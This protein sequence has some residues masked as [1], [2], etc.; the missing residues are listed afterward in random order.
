MVEGFADFY[1]AAVFNQFGPGAWLGK[2]DIENDTRRYFAKCPGSLNS[3]VMQGYCGVQG[4]AT[5]CADAGG[6]NE[7]DWA[8]T[9][10]DFAKV[11]GVDE[12]PAVLLLLSDAIKLAWDPGSTTIDAYN[13]MR[14]AANLRFPAN[15]DDFHASAQAN[16]TNR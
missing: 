15:G 4:D 8:G 14:H 1:A 11:V 10:W 12:M 9:L 3:L 6:S 5:M 7:T 16:G 13:N 2:N